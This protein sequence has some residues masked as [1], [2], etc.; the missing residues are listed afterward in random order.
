MAT[1]LSLP[2]LMSRAGISRILA[3]CPDWTTPSGGVKKI[4]RHVD[5][6]NSNGINAAVVH[7]PRG[8]RCT[9]FENQTRVVYHDDIWPP[10]P[11]ELLL[12]PELLAWQ[13]L[14]MTPGI[15]KVV[16]NQNVYQLFQDPTPEINQLL[17]PYNHPD[18]LAT[19]VVS[20]DSRRY[21]NFGFAGHP[22][23]RLRNSVDPRLF[24]FEPNKKPQ[25]ALMPR[26]KKT[27][28]VQILHLLNF[29]HGADGFSVV[30]IHNVA[31][32][33]SA[34]VLREAQV[35]LSL[36]TYEGSPLP[37]L[38]AMA[39]GCITVGYHGRGGAEYVNEANAFPIEAEDIVG[40]A[41]KLE[42]VLKQLRESPQPLLEKARRA[43]DF[44]LCT[45]TPEHEEQDILEAW[46]PIFELAITRASG[47]R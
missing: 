18:F 30:P 16:F 47:A 4:Y 36:C 37:P 35:F 34:R 11:D 26:K 3:P 2:D 23:F 27:D 29:R 7:M 1:A 9:W 20:E 24:Y 28:A 41:T 21:I 46:K 13:L 33:E 8:F 32:A 14:G 45:Y 44:V 12:V 6:L 15:R 42:W 5:V 17:S 19:I 22:V 40:F 38:E 10:R 43:S 31:E 25:I 39:C